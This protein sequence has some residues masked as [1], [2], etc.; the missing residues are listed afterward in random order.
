MSNHKESEELMKFLNYEEYD[1]HAIDS[2]IQKRINELVKCWDILSSEMMI[3]EDTIHIADVLKHSIMQHF[4]YEIV[5]QNHEEYL[6]LLQNFA[7]L[8]FTKRTKK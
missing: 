2:Q 7:Y 5:N 6:S 3:C 4:G 8:E 1:K